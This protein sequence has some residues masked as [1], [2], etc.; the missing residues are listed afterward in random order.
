M[1]PPVQTLAAVAVSAERARRELL[2]NMK[3][4]S[5]RRFAMRHPEIKVSHNRYS[6]ARITAIAAANPNR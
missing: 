2:D 6:V 5:F 4:R 1:N 3:L